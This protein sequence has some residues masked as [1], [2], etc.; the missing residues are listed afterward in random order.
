MAKLRDNNHF[1]CELPE[2]MHEQFKTTLLNP[3]LY[4]VATLSLLFIISSSIAKNPFIFSSDTT[5]ATWSY[6]EI[7][8]MKI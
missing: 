3:S 2:K 4:A 5:D 8:T 1:S 7:A 6:G